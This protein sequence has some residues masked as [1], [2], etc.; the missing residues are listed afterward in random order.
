MC[1]K[2]VSEAKTGEKDDPYA[3]GQGTGDVKHSLLYREKVKGS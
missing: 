1:A 3:Y 2:L